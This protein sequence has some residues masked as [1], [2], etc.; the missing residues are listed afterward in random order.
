M[1]PPSTI[2]SLGNWD[3]RPQQEMSTMYQH[4]L[5][6]SMVGALIANNFYLFIYLFLFVIIVRLLGPRLHLCGLFFH[7][8]MPKVFFALIQKPD[9]IHHSFLV[10]VDTLL[11]YKYLP[12][13]LSV[14][15]M[16]AERVGKQCRRQKKSRK[17]FNQA[18]TISVLTRLSGIAIA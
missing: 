5:D 8:T 14:S 18:T 3:C 17:V 7:Y 11:R 1:L 13:S 9:L 4:A 15:V 16:I 2:Y 10:I 12:S 6:A